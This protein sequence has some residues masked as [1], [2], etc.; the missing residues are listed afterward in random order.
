MVDI[1]WDQMASKEATRDDGAAEEEEGGAGTSGILAW[2]NRRIA[3]RPL[4][5]RAVLITV[6]R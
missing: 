3:E 5:T 4:V 2:Y 1:G 6:G